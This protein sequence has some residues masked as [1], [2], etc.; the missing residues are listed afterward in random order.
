MSEIV[1]KFLLT[2]DKCMPIF[3]PEQPTTSAKTVGF[4]YSACGSFTKCH[5]RIQKSTEKINKKYIYSKESDKVCFIHDVAYA[6][7]KHLAKRTISG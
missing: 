3:I 2:G 7:S 1:N 5:D 6:D 4:L